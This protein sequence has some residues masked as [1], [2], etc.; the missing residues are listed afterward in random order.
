M[1]DNLLNI[2]NFVMKCIEFQLGLKVEKIIERTEKSPD[3]LVQCGKYKYLIELKSKWTKKEFLK[4]REEELLSGKIFEEIN[5]AGRKIPISRVVESACR[6]LKKSKIKS[7]FKLVW[8]HAKGHNHYFQVE[9][10]ESTLY[11]REY[12]ADW[13]DNKPL[14]YCYFFDKSDFYFHKNILD[15]AII[16]DDKGMKLCL[17]T[18]SPG[19]KEFNKCKLREAF[20]DAVIDPVDA[21]I[22]GK[23]FLVDP[24]F[25]R[26]HG[27]VIGYLTEKYNLKK[28]MKMPMQQLSGTMLLPKK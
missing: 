17:N 13:G 22:N 12:I 21:E 14:V 15:G 25:D 26:N 28:P 4:Y 5:P 2:E 24:E 6:Q 20:Q 7:D 3:F 1:E 23:A 16:S 8:L 10:F 11:G 27:D 18:L 9:D 19:Y